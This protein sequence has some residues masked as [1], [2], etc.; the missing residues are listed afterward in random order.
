MRCLALVVSA[1]AHACWDNML[2][3]M[4]QHDPDISFIHMLWLR[5]A[6]MAVGLNLMTWPCRH[7]EWSQQSVTW[8][9]KF[10][11]VG[12]VI[13]TCTYSVAVLWTGY[14]IAVSFQPFIP[15]LVAA[16]LGAPWSTRQCGA[17]IL[18]M[19]GTLTIWSYLAWDHELWMVHLAILS[20]VIHAACVAEW[21]VMLDNIQT[22][23]LAHMARGTIIGVLCLFF[24]MI[25][26]TPQ[27]LEAAF[28]YRADI[29]LLLMVATGTAALC[30]YWLVAYF[31]TAMATDAIAIF[32]CVHP[33]ATL[34]SDVIREKDVF[35]YQDMIAIAF[36]LLGWILYPK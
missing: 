10:S 21:F 14:R 12:W 15:L 30:K 4:V 20:S 5:M 8:W 18:A 1:V 17:L 27:H 28:V 36:F 2:H 6:I 31:S 13:P 24:L 29:W 34:C 16:R 19:C 23:V 25:M 9:L 32:E 7:V 3:W 11:V 35:E 26:W 33:I 22:N